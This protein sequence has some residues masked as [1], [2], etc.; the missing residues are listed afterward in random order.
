MGILGGFKDSK[1][2]GFKDSTCQDFGVFFW[3]QFDA[4]TLL[5][6]G[7]GLDDDWKEPARL[8]ATGIAG[9]RG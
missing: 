5:M 6:L 9:H 7:E 3:E 2:L 8:W 1:I 4:L